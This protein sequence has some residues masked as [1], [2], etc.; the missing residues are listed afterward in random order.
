MKVDST[1]KQILHILSNNS[2]IKLTDLAQR[3]HLS[4][5]ATKARLLNLEDHD[6]IQ[7]YT[8]DIN[9][10]NLGYKV[11]VFLH[12]SLHQPRMLTFNKIINEWQENMIRCCRSSGET[13]FIYEARFKSQDQLYR[14]INQVSKVAAYRVYAILK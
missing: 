12:F 13:D 7:R 5:P 1:D 8:I 10:T 11:H 14:F 9:H 6:V 2:R 3:I 4:A